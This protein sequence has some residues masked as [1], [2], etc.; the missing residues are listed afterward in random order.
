MLELQNLCFNVDAEGQDKEIIQDVSLTLPDGQL[1]V[2]TG[3]VIGAVLPNQNRCQNAD[4]QDQ[5]H[6][7]RNDQTASLP[8]RATAD[9]LLIFFNISGFALTDF[10]AAFN[11]CAAIFAEQRPLR[12]LSATLFTI[13]RQPLFFC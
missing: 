12:D 4:G 6:D 10:F 1:T 3:L 2:I 8:G 7:Q 5:D 9:T 11:P 13:H